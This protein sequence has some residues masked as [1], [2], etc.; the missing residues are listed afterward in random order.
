MAIWGE[1]VYTYR[2]T[3]YENFAIVVGEMC[4]IYDECLVGKTA[5]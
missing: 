4:A 2:E 1:N 5:E 3:M